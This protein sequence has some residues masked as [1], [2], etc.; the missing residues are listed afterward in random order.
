MGSSLAYPFSYSYP[1]SDSS[2]LRLQNYDL[3]FDLG[4]DPHSRTAHNEFP[5][6][7][8]SLLGVICLIHFLG[9]KPSQRHLSGAC[10]GVAL[11]YHIH[12][13]EYFS[14]S[15]P[16]T[17]KGWLHVGISWQQFWIELASAEWYWS[18]CT[19]LHYMT[20]L[21]FIFRDCESGR[22]CILCDN[23]V[24]N[25]VPFSF[26]RPTAIHKH[27]QCITV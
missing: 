7:H 21:M 1:R 12:T 13:E 25:D 14:G 26:C 15:Y 17:C 20:K 27:S 18:W 16:A 19:S 9:C 4:V 23:S 3:L 5:W 22:C 6:G 8:I 24:C 11:Y 10:S 2:F